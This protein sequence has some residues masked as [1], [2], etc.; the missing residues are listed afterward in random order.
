MGA[1]L[2]GPVAAGL[3]SAEAMVVAACAQLLAAVL[4]LVLMRLPTRAVATEA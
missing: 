3:G 4:G 2:A 1:A